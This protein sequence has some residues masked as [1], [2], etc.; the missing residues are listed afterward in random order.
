M[1]RTLDI[2]R[3]DAFSQAT[4]RTRVLGTMPW[5][6]TALER[7]NLFGTPIGIETTIV[8][9]YEEAGKITLI[10]AT[11]RGSPRPQA[12]RRTGAFKAVET[13]RLTKED[14]VQAAELNANITNM[15]FPLQ[16][17]MVSAAELVTDRMTQLRR[18]MAATKSLHMLGAVQGKILD[19]DAA[20]VL[21]NFFDLL[22]VAE[23]APV[24]IDFDNV[25]EDDLAADIQ[26]DFYIPA[27]RTIQT[28]N[29][30]GLGDGQGIQLAAFCGDNFWQKIIRH[31]AVRKRWEAAEMGRAIA[32]GVNPLTTP[33]VWESVDLGNVRWF[34]FMGAL[35]GPLAIPTDEAIIFPLNA[36]DVF[37]QYQS[38]G[39]TLSTAVG[40]GQE[41]YPLI[42]VDPRDDPEFIDI[43]LSSYPLYACIYPQ[44]LQRATL[45]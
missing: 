11:G 22:G 1:E 30:G 13:L 16:A 2:F 41:L 6:P 31:P 9:I 39:E 32:F 40:K 19:A 12:D 3:N 37:E 14:H 29:G 45:P 28:R 17:R 21:V 8:L 24:E 15:A 42:R 7:L 38:P 43:I 25:D 35:T 18:D 10:P 33:P 5:Q 44:I 34:H 26:Q 27:V 36:P 20:T 4:L 23:P